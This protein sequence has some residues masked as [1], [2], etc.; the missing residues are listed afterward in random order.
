[1]NSELTGGE[2]GLFAYYN[3]NEG[4]GQTAGD[5]SGNGRDGTLGSTTSSDSADPAWTSDQPDLITTDISWSP[6]NPEEGDD[7]TFSATIKNQGGASTPDGTVHGVNFEVD[8]TQ[9]SWSSSD[10]S[11][12]DPGES[13]TVT[14]DGGPDDD[15]FWNSA[16]A[17]DHIVTATVDDVDRI[18]ESDETNNSM[19]ET[20]TVQEADTT[21]PTL[22]NIQASNITESSATI[23]WDTDEPATAQVEFGTDTSY[24]S[25]TPIVDEGNTSHSIDLFELQAG[26][27]YHYRVRSE[28][29]SGNEAVSSDHT[30]TTQ[31]ADTTP[32]TS[33]TR[34]HGQ[35][36]ITISASASDDRDVAKVELLVDG[37]VVATK[38]SSLFSFTWDST[39]V[40]NGE[41]IIET[42]AYDEAGNTGTSTKTFVVVEN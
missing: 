7:V 33:K 13:I 37:T 20:V 1:M 17:G 2:T 28:D 39:T 10:T 25:L 11:S 42:K 29:S 30:F 22:S 21:P 9:V 31:E 8:D 36:N 4:T 3:L 35:G 26:T 23:I 40:A 27:T 41:H 19:D 38:T 34:M 15:R 32:P 16:T 18:T 24:G 14:A 12:L 5:S 6:T